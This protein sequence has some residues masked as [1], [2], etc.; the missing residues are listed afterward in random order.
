MTDPWEGYP[1]KRTFIAVG[2]TMVSGLVIAGLASKFAWGWTAAAASTFLTLAV[3]AGY[4]IITKDEL[5]GKL[6]AFGVVVGFGELFTDAW[7]VSSVKVLVYPPQPLIWDSPFY[8]PFSWTG[9]MVQLGF[10]S[11]WLYSKWGVWWAC[12]IMAVIGGSNLPLGEYL[13]KGAE[14][15]H[16]VDCKMLFGSTPWFVILGEVFIGALMPVIVWQVIRRPWGWVVPLG[17]A[18]AV[19]LFLCS[20]AAWAIVEGF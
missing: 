4:A 12:G 16:Y 13:A 18:M 11:V 17:A 20:I 6:C 3:L 7:A 2:T 8:M 15:W 9:L 14:F 10:I 1:T 5:I 19:W